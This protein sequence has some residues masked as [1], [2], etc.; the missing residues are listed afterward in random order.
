MFQLV[1][2]ARELVLGEI[3]EPRRELLSRAELQNFNDVQIEFLLDDRIVEGLLL[4]GFHD[5]DYLFVFLLDFGWR[6]VGQKVDEVLLLDLSDV[7]EHQELLDGLLGIEFLVYL[8]L[9]SLNVKLLVL[10]NEHARQEAV[11]APL[12]ALVEKLAALLLVVGVLE[13]VLLL[14]S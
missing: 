5:V 3:P 8:D 11:I 7:I 4:H 6:V 1:S 10:V 12:D 2:K 13:A 9:V 14:L